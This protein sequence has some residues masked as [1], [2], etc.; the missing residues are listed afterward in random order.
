MR[1]VIE[2]GLSWL[3]YETRSVFWALVRALVS[4]SRSNGVRGAS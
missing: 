2:A 3:R 1:R 4:S